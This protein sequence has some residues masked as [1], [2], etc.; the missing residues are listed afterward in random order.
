MST[1]T[2]ALGSIVPLLAVYDMRRTVAFYRDV[3]GFEVEAE[4]EQDGHL[5]WAAMKCGDTRLMFNA[6]YEDHERKPEHDRPHGKD[7]I[8]YFSPED[9]VALRESLAQKGCEVGNL[10]V[11][12]YKH[13]QFDVKDPDGYTLCFTQPTDEPPN[14]DHA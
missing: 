2:P 5:Y 13:K 14:D 8:F 9:V 6:E 12:H 7:V 10:R 4:W 3:L 1:T 11:T